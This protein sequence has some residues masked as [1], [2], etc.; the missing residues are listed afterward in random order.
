MIVKKNPRDGFYFLQFL[1]FVYKSIRIIYIGW[2]YY[3]TPFLAL[4]ITFKYNADDNN[5]SAEPAT[6]D[7]Q[8]DPL[9]SDDLTTPLLNNP[10]TLFSTF[11]NETL[12][13]Y[14]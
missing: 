13:L 1:R 12:P 4:A 10:T 8:I 14:Y 11:G 9:Q 6:V 2:I 5:I 7:E 3:F